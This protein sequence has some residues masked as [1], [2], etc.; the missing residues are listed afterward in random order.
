MSVSLKW[1]RG[2]R[3]LMAAAALTSPLM[4]A[5]TIPALAGAGQ[6]AGGTATA[7]GS[8]REAGGALLPAPLSGS[9]RMLQISRLDLP[10]PVGT[11]TGASFIDGLA[12]TDTDESFATLP[13]PS[14]FV[15]SRPSIGISSAH[16]G[17]DASA[18]RDLAF[19]LVLELPIITADGADLA[20]TY[21]ALAERLGGSLPYGSALSFSGEEESATGIL[22]DIDDDNSGLPSGMTWSEGAAGQPALHH[23]PVAIFNTN[24]DVFPPMAF[25][26]QGLADQGI[27]P[28]PLL[29]P[30]DAP[31]LKMTPA[32]TEEPEGIWP[33]PAQRM[34]LKGAT[35]E[36]AQKCLAEAVYFES[37]GE[38]K[39]GQVAVAQVVIN[40]VF[41]GY[42]PADICGTVYQNA[43]RK[44]ACQFTFACDDVK[45]VVREPA[46]WVQA[47]EIA[48]DMLD[49][50]LWLESVGRATHYH[51]HWVNPNW[52]SEMRKLDRIGVHT[53]Y[54][55]LNWKS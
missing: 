48:T 26:Y 44:L 40:R 33:S 53:F 49:G 52:V 8:P 13:A 21:G 30:A 20:A 55:P 46:M 18:L 17:D 12:A 3:T 9:M 38:P 34:Q 35:L 54:R 25:E 2:L 5:M 41:S 4:G 15:A 36:K 16:A 14:V 11:G 27:V 39:R 29:Q 45:D 24:P 23:D 47:N 10:Q 19:D 50:K 1:Q 42:Y 43:N 22:P 31:R 6:P 28:L 32:H 37:R 51:A 7:T